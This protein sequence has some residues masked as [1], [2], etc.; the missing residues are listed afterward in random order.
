ME[1]PGYP[2]A[3]H[4]LIVTGL[5]DFDTYWYYCVDSCNDCSSD[6]Y[7]ENEMMPV[8]VAKTLP[9]TLSC[10][11]EKMEICAVIWRINI[12]EEGGTIYAECLCPDE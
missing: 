12:D 2:P 9:C 7:N 4:V 6:C 11:F 8:A 5:C 1:L 10:T 3:C